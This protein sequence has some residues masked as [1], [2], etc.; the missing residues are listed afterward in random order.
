MGLSFIPFT[1][2][3]HFFAEHKARPN[4]GKLCS[5][6]RLH[7]KPLFVGLETAFAQ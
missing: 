5:H 7:P 1:R 2:F 6:L 4:S 3:S